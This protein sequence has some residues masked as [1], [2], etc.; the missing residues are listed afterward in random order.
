MND[1]K[2]LSNEELIYLIEVFSN[3]GVRK[4]RFTGGSLCFDPAL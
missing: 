3:L 2:V 4:I 1:G